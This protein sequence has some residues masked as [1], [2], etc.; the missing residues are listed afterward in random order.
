[1]HQTAQ[2]RF[3]CRSQLAGDRFGTAEAWI[4][5]KLAPT[6]RGARL[7]TELGAGMLSPLDQWS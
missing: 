3:L 4:A 2:H 5:S 6:K 7:D 1:M